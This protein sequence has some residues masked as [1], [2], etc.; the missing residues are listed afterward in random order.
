MADAPDRKDMGRR[1]I[2]T[3][4]SSV[5]LLVIVAV[6]SI[7]PG[8]PQSRRVARPVMRKKSTPGPMIFILAVIMMFPALSVASGYKLPAP[9]TTL[10]IPADKNN[11]TVQVDGWTCVILAYDKAREI[12]ELISK[13]PIQELEYIRSFATEI[14][15]SDKYGGDLRFF[16]HLYLLAGTELQG[17]ETT[18]QITRESKW[19]GCYSSEELTRMRREMVRWAKYVLDKLGA[20]PVIEFRPRKVDFGALAAGMKAQQ[21]IRVSNAGKFSTASFRLVTS[22]NANYSFK[23]LSVNGVSYEAS[24][25]E[26][27]KVITL[28]PGESVSAVVELSLDSSINK[29][30]Q[31]VISNVGADGKIQ[32]FI[33]GD[34]LNAKSSKKQEKGGSIWLGYLNFDAE[35]SP[36]SLQVEIFDA[37]DVADNLSENNGLL[38]GREPVDEAMVYRRA[39]NKRVGYVADGNAALL[40]RA[41]TNNADRNILFKLEGKKK[42]GSLARL[43]SDPDSLRQSVKAEVVDKKNKLYQATSVIVSPE[44]FP[45]GYGGSFS[46]TTCLESLEKKGECDTGI[47]PVRKYLD[48]RKAPVVLVHG[49]WAGPE[50]W[51]NGD[52]GLLSA[53]QRNGYKVFAVKYPGDRGPSETMKSN[54]KLL[55]G[56]ILNLCL[57]HMRE[58]YACTRADLVAH[59][60]GGLVSRKFI[61]DNNNYYNPSNFNVGSVRRLITIDT[62]HYGSGFAN[63][64]SGDN[65]RINNCI[66]L[67]KTGVVAGAAVKGG[68]RGGFGGALKG[69]LISASK[70]WPYLK[71]LLTVLKIG[72]M[73]PYGTAVRD[74]KVG[75]K[76]LN[77]LNSDTQQV[78]SFALIGDTGH[79]LVVTKGRDLTSFIT[80]T[81]CSHKDLFGGQDSD[82]IV[83][84]SSQNGRSKSAI[85]P[86]VPHLGEGV[87]KKVINRVL[88]LLQDPKDSFSKTAFLTDPSRPLR[89]NSNN[90]P[91]A[92]SPFLPNI[93]NLWASLTD[94]LISEAG[95]AEKNTVNLT[96]SVKRPL[97]GQSFMLRLE[98]VAAGADIVMLNDGTVG[99]GPLHLLSSPPYQWEIKLPPDFSGSRTFRASVIKGEQVTAS[100]PVTISYQPN[101]S[102]LKRLTFSPIDPLVLHPGQTRQL[103]VTG[104]FADGYD[105]NLTTKATGITYSEKIV[106]GLERKEA[107]SGSI[108]I[109]EN[110]LLSALKPGEAVVV[111]H[112]GDFTTGKR[113]SVV[114]V[115]PLDADGDGL[116]DQREKEIGT[117]PFS[118][119]SDGDGSGDMIEVGGDMQHPLKMEDKGLIN[120]LNPAVITIQDGLK[121]YIS[122]RAT[123]G[124]LVSATI[125][126]EK[127]FP[128]LSDAF[129]GQNLRNGILDMEISAIQGQQKIGVEVIFQPPMDD[130][131]TFMILAET[132][133]G[134]AAWHQYRE[135][136][137]AQGYAVMT[138]IDNGSEDSDPEK[139]SIRITG[140]FAGVTK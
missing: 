1:R 35:L 109:S 58:G 37:T 98:G 131:S 119:D 41:Q 44:R 15:D 25:K 73:N 11:A 110:G 84:L 68:L 87:N 71:V 100:N 113:I 122:V 69:T 13:Q 117:N 102:R 99:L 83:S 38:N 31:N 104:R 6:L 106:D 116:T 64:L 133:K 22:A 97:P 62:P 54:S 63:L 16:D 23:V 123:G 39:K 86:G 126:D 34:E 103:M 139:G 79:K 55:L 50:S 115:S 121:Q 140:G 10:S 91:D 130:L 89:Q 29:R 53:L 74:L 138:F 78:T 9:K 46:I 17:T 101:L 129:P 137:M 107:D 24:N 72:G 42:Y 108:D 75:S 51:G 5:F 60:M 27:I 80:P 125:Q 32:Y 112:V 88:K 14:I 45:E 8:K 77:S 85:M 94:L 18:L 82:S 19:Q 135:L 21:T 48:L 114:P 33:M 49:L 134:G 3:A 67:E 92:G 4:I 105:R 2:M 56:P 66:K 59:S 132:G 43:D 111:A 70:G 76:F 7:Y 93:P 136:R 124:K 127:Y 47:R 61:K 81:G 36:T 65:S 128:S 20:P 96:L 12:N 118:P 52:F 26:D 120:A 95:A 40:V 90:V 57:Q 30:S 28:E